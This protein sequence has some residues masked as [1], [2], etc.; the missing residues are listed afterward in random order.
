MGFDLGHAISSLSKLALRTK[1]RIDKNSKT[2]IKDFFNE[3]LIKNDNKYSSLMFNLYE[4]EQLYS[5]EA[6]Y[7]NVAVIRRNSPIEICDKTNDY[8]TA[9]SIVK[10]ELSAFYRDNKEQLKNISELS[11]GFVDGDLY[12]IK[13][14]PLK[15]E[16]KNNKK[17]TFDE[18]KKFDPIKI[19]AWTTVY[20]KKEIKDTIKIPFCNDFPKMSEDELN[21]WISLLVENFDYDKYNSKNNYKFVEEKRIKNKY[22]KKIQIKPYLVEMMKFY[23]PS[24]ELIHTKGMFYMFR[25][26]LGNGLY[27]YIDFQREGL[28]YNQLAITWCGVGYNQNWKN[29][30]ASDF[31]GH[32]KDIS[33]LLKPDGFPK[34]DGWVQYGETVEE[35]DKCMLELKEQ[36][37]TYVFPY[38]EEVKKSLLN[39]QIMRGDELMNATVKIMKKELPKENPNDVKE[40][41]RLMDE[42]AKKD[43]KECIYDYKNYSIWH[44]LINQELKSPVEFNQYI[45]VYLKDYYQHYY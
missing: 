3:V 29:G 34:P 39:T 19:G 28:P 43:E 44:N 1:R 12:Y 9:L 4:D 20:L 21:K 40:I 41:I 7:D 42:G 45:L 33:Y 11:Y 15:S 14:E 22:T 27:G 25:S 32:L 16:L 18:I 17:F 5:I 26:E 37:E 31:I 6:V 30:Q 35:I 2:T 38:F 13:Q 8:K 23:F 10:E 24:Y 36:I